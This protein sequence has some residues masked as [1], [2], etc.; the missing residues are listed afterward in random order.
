MFFSSISSSLSQ[1][2]WVKLNSLLFLKYG[3]G[4]GGQAKTTSKKK[5]KKNPMYI[6]IISH[7]QQQQNGMARLMT[8]DRRRASPTAW[9]SQIMLR[10]Q[11][12]TT[13]DSR[14]V[15]AW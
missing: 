10:Q 6:N 2:N 11:V 1:W 7:Q 13:R 8:D 14:K 9:L 12:S 3:D 4:G 15:Y 5:N